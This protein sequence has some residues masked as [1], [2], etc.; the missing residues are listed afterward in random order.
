MDS[1]KAN[2]ISAQ[3]F[4]SEGCRICYETPKDIK[5]VQILDTMDR[6]ACNSYTC[7]IRCFQAFQASDRNKRLNVR[8]GKIVGW[9]SPITAN[10]LEFSE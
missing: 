6:T 1:L 10:F 3:S 4:F 5:Y 2:I 9:V 7:C 8:E